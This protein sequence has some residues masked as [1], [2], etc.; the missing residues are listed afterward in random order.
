MKKE[1]FEKK[2]NGAITYSLINLK[3]LFYIENDTSNTERIY[4]Y[5]M[6]H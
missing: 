6:Y 2:I 3:Y 5:I 4:N 1:E